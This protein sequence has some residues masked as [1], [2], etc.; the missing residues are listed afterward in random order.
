MA[1]AIVSSIVIACIGDA[2]FTHEFGK[3]ALWRSYRKMKMI[4]HED[5]AVKFHPIDSK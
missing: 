5:I 1:C 2:E 3:I 4:L